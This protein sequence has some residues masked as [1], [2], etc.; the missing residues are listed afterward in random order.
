VRPSGA[1]SGKVIFLIYIYIFIYF[2]K[3]SGACN[4]A[5]Q[6]IIKADKGNDPNSFAYKYAQCAKSAYS[7]FTG[8]STEKFGSCLK[9]D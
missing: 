3:S 1:G 9:G 4:T 7:I 8:W 6:A 5:E 2:V